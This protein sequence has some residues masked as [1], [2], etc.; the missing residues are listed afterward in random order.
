[1]TIGIAGVENDR[2]FVLSGEV[3][4]RLVA[5]VVGELVD[6]AQVDLDAAIF[7]GFQTRFH[8][9]NVDLFVDP[10]AVPDLMF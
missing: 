6:V 3:V 4:S 5:R 8:A 2:Y 9:R 7:S 10:G 1:M